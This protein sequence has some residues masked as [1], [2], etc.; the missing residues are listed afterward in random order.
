MLYL[1]LAAV[2]AALSGA[3]HGAAPTPP[4]ATLSGGRVG[5]C[6]DVAE[7]PP[8]TYYRRENGRKTKE[9]RG[10]SLRVVEAI[11]ARHGIRY[12]IQLLP[13]KRC[14]LEVAGG[15]RFQM[16]L[17]ATSNPER[18]AA[19][20]FSR[21]YYA[22]HYHYFYS[23]RAH[24]EGLEIRRPADLNRYTLGGIAG[25]AYSQLAGVD[26]GA[27]MRTVDYPA[28]VKMLRAGRFDAFAEDIEVIEGMAKLGERD[29]LRGG[30]LAHAPLPGAGEN[31]FHMMFTRATPLGAALQALIDR[32]LARMEKSGQLR[33]LLDAPMP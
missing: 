3:A 9:V 27:M 25:Y 17:S 23:R 31:T 18:R 7:W 13:W 5:I 15:A 22:T 24:P 28:L 14:L 19:Y 6:D 11:F 1:M 8:Y 30:E 20:L 2:L 21:P 32:E 26:T 29:F 4:P 33:K 16:L 10:N 12:E